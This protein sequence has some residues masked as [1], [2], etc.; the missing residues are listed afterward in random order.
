MSLCEVT[1]IVLVRDGG[2]GSKQTDCRKASIE[3][4]SRP[5][6]Q[7][8][9]RLEVREEARVQVPGPWGLGDNRCHPPFGDTHEFVKG[10]C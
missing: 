7:S 4:S 5:W 1:G 2:N 3:R 8:G 9:T 10:R 6:G